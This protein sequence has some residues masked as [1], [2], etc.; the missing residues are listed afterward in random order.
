MAD[1]AAAE[2]IVDDAKSPEQLPGAIKT[3]KELMVGQ[4]GGLERQYQA[5]TG[6]SDF[7]TKFLSP[8]AKAVQ[9]GGAPDIHSAADAILRGK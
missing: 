1:R 2:K 8:E 5:T 7:K 4:L 9:S 3:I 6:R